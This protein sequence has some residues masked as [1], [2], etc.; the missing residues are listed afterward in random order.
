MQT[1]NNEISGRSRTWIAILSILVPIL[2]TE[3]IQ[4][5]TK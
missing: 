5:L 2:L 1:E 3:L 4:Y